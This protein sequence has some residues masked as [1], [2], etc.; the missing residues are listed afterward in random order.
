MKL[1]IVFFILLLAPVTRDSLESVMVLHMFVQL[2]LLI[3]VGVLSHGNR[4]WHFL[5]K[6]N[7]NGVAGMLLAVGVLFFWMLPRSLDDALTETGMEVWKFVSLPLLGFLWRNSWRKLGGI[8][9]SF[10]HIN[11]LSMFG[12]LAWLYLG[13]PVQICNNYLINEQQIVGAVYLSVVLVSLLYLVYI[14]FFRG[15]VEE[16]K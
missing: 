4:N 11:F 15:L 6:W 3:L 8:F 7:E 9:K 10:L 1:A 14:G 12:L 2:P 5:E 13:T 16:A